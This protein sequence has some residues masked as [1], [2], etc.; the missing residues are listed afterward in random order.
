MVLVLV[1]PCVV[2]RSPTHVVACSTAVCSLL[3]G[4]HHQFYF[5][6]H[7]ADVVL[8]YNE[9]RIVLSSV[10]KPIKS[11]FLTAVVSTL[12]LE[13]SASDANPLKCIHCIGDLSFSSSSSRSSGSLSSASPFF[14]ASTW[15]RLSHT[16]PL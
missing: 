8:R 9:L 14:V 15:V 3:G 10:L 11:L 6:F 12:G 2:A 4:L 1:T 13:H 7:L 16:L 5:S